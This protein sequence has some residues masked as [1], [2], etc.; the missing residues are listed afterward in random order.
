MFHR[1]ARTHPERFR[2]GRCPPPSTSTVAFVAPGALTHV[3]STGPRITAPKGR[4]WGS[5]PRI[6]PANGTGGLPSPAFGTGMRRTK[7]GFASPSD[8]RALSSTT[9]A[10]ASCSFHTSRGASSTTVARPVSMTVSL[11]PTRSRC[12]RGANIA[13]L[14]ARST[15]TSPDYTL[16]VPASLG[17]A[18][19]WAARTT[20]ASSCTMGS[21]L[22]NNFQYN[23]ELRRIC[24]LQTESAVEPGHSKGSPSRRARGRRGREL[25]GSRRL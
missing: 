5:A 10:P 7:T 8:F 19:G 15:R 17:K 2:E 20:R 3:T 13:S 6:A 16:S 14:P 12:A 18:T 23:F 24:A 21:H 9:N 22:T 4:I 1:P 25:T 11:S